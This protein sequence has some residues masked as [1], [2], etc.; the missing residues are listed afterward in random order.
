MPLP[1]VP[2]VLLLLLL[3]TSRRSDI[4]ALLDGRG[5]FRSL[6]RRALA[7]RPLPPPMVPMAF[8]M[9]EAV[10]AA[11]LI[12]PL[13]IG[14]AAMLLPALLTAPAATPAARLTCPQV[15]RSER[16]GSDM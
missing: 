16:P 12:M 13:A 5:R 1:K 15:D 2:L 3:I 10:E 7:P 11:T 4:E 8:E 9:L 14:S 6:N